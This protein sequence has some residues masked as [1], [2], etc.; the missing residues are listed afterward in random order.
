MVTNMTLLTLSGFHGN[1]K[2]A[3]LDSDN[4][5]WYSWRKPMS[6]GAT[7]HYQERFGLSISV[8]QLNCVRASLGLSRHRMSRE[9]T[10]GGNRTTPTLVLDD[11]KC[12]IL[13]TEPTS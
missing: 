5:R 11:G 10:Q 3:R 2:V 13:L 1:V 8:S 9:K 7:R 12:R 4:E 6:R